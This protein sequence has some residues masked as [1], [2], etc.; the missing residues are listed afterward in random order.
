MKGEQFQSGLLSVFPGQSTAQAPRPG[1]G[2]LPRGMRLVDSTKGLFKRRVRPGVS[3]S[4]GAGGA[5]SASNGASTVDAGAEYAVGPD[6]VLQEAAAAA[7]GAASGSTYYPESSYSPSPGVMPSYEV[8][9]MMVSGDIEEP[10]EGIMG[11][12]EKNPLVSA[13]L[14][15]TVGFIAFRLAQDRGIV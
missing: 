3:S 4:G 8:D 2:N 11:F 12:V 9:T 1:S 5:S 13:L 10:K 14:A 6:T 7:A 15:G